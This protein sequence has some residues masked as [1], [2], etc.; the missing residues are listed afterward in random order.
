MQVLVFYG[1]TALIFLAAD[2]LMLRTIMKPL[3]ERHLGDWL[4]EPIRLGP[5]VAFYLAYVAGAIWLVGWPALKAGAPGTALVNGAVLGALAYGTY[6]FTNLATLK[7]W[8]WE[9]VAMDTTWGAVLTGLSLWAG[10]QIAK[11]VA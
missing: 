5:A 10:L 6:E 9:Q 1:A 3:F 11:A 8:S 7:R 2:A 4:L